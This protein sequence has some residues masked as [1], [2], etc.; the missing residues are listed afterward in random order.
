ME[1]REAGR[2]QR[3]IEIAKT[4]LKMGLSVNDIMQLTGL[5]HRANKN[6]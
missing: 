4:A 6:K 3:E 5:N 1:G 2:E